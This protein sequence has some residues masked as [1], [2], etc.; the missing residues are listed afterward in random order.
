MSWFTCTFYKEV[1]SRRA[2]NI[3][4]DLHSMRLE[5][6]VVAHSLLTSLDK[7]LH[8]L[9]C[10]LLDLLRNCQVDREAL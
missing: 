3:N 10:N 5:H 7:R 9:V 6:Q 1:L 8:V 4:V 2:S